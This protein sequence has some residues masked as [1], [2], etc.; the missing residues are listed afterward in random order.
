MDDQNLFLN[1]RVRF[2]SEMK[3]KKFAFLFA[4][5]ALLIQTVC[6]QQGVEK[7]AVRWSRGSSINEYLEKYSKAETPNKEVI[8]DAQSYSEVSSDASVEKLSQY[9]GKSNVLKWTDESGEV[10]WPFTVEESGIYYLTMDYIA[11]PFKGME[12]EFEVKLDGKVPY[13]D[14]QAVRFSRVWKDATEIRKDKNGNEL[15]SDEEEVEMWQTR[16]FIDT[17][18]FFNEPLPLYMEVG[19]HELTLKL[20]REALC[21]KEIR[22]G[23]IEELP[24]YSEIADK[25]SSYNKPQN[26]FVKVQ[27]EHATLKSDSVLIATSDRIDAATE[28]SSPS[29]IR[30]NTIGGNYTWKL[31]GQ[32]IE[33]EIEAPEDGLYKLF[34][35]ARQNVQRGMAA[36]RKVYIDGQIPS[37]EFENL[38]FPYDLKWKQ[39]TPTSTESGEP[40]LV[41]LTKGKHT[42]RLENSLGR[43][44]PILTSVD[45]LTYECN[46]LRRRFIMIMG[47]EPDL[48]R[49]YQLDK[50]IPGLVE[51]LHE[52]A[53]RFEQQAD[54]FEEITGQKGTEAQTLRIMVDQLNLFADQPEYIPNRQSSFRDNITNLATWI[55]A[56]K[57]VP[58][59]IDYLGIMSADAKMP[60]ARANWFVQRWMDIRSFFAS[61]VE[62]Y[63]SIGGK[64]KE[65][66]TV[67]ISSGR[68]Q[69]QILRNLITNDF[70]P[71]TGIKVNL[72]LVQGTIIEAT[73]AGRGPDIA[74]QVAR[75]QP[76][77][78]AARNALYDLKKFPDYDQ[79][80][81][82]F[83]DNAMVP[84]E[85]R[86][87][88]YA[89]P[90][91]QDFHMMFYRTDI[92]EELGIE[93]PETWD[94]VYKI[95]P[96]LQRNNMQ[97]GLPYQSA[98]GI[99]L[100]DAGMG[101]R[102]LFP[103]LLTQHGGSFYKNDFK[104]TALTDPEAYAAFKQWIDFYSSYGF[105]LKFDFYNR[106]R[107]GEMPLGITSYGQYNMLMAAA[108][109]IRNLW[110]M[111]PIPGIRQED[112]TINRN[113]SA[114]GSAMIMFKKIKNPEDGWEFMKWW[115]R[116]DIQLKYATQL[117]TLMGP[118][119]RLGTANVDTFKRMAWSKSEQE[120]LESQ[121]KNVDEI[122]E[123]PGGYYTI[124]MLDIAFTK[125]Y[126][127]NMNARATLNK[128]CEMINEE[129]LR[130]RKELGIDD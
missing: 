101:S 51:K 112:G 37:K 46:T 94:D 62:D 29:K 84:Y 93:P 40:C 99:D 56:R 114:S 32:W 17:Q 61:F 86:G 58:V 118:A 11:L 4:V 27:G 123:I 52:L 24:R 115:T 57:E 126:Y 113:E 75:G 82:R 41:H 50:E 119:A 9:K 65:A 30:L 110:A 121:W 116:S 127:N 12:I 96:T 55:L 72:S 78:L 108:P 130:K 92:F 106:F 74:I 90:L 22:I 10:T 109:E 129:I 14:F 124:R 100:I 47:S 102:N 120:I 31:P 3:K 97:I 34:I 16:Q 85:Y 45:D 33:W 25:Y 1:F 39:F 76:V 77:N 71:N 64:E 104:E 117:E 128:Y 15:V 103:T 38:E 111:R 69:A 18:G 42:I 95:I 5:A 60:K 35:K 7:Q 79:V 105:T 53:S 6:A 83:R 13:D 28:P 81:K 59:E 26:V 63:N 87:G 68:D 8:I 67:W 66:I 23:G 21:I 107:T 43:L 2:C 44:T 73:M 98:D 54:E 20:K 91:T 80:T 70:T 36:T 88:A 89:L 125:S 122:P 19:K 48:Y 49:D